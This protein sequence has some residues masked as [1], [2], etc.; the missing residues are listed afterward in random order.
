MA[1]LAIFVIFVFEYSGPWLKT[2]VYAAVERYMLEKEKPSVE[3][4]KVFLCLM[5]KLRDTKTV[6]IWS[7]R[8]L[9]LFYCHSPITQQKHVTSLVGVTVQIRK[10]K[11]SLPVLTCQL[12]NTQSSPFFAQQQ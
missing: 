11:Q 4:V 9:C 5:K 8:Q 3:L 1:S 7:K 6:R 2:R 10:T 12:S